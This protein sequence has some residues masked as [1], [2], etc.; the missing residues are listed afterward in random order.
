MERK[1]LIQKSST[2]VVAHGVIAL[3]GLGLAGY[4]GY[5]ITVSQEWYTYTILIIA[6]L[7]GILYSIAFLR[8]ILKPKILAEYDENNLY[9]IKRN[10]KDVAL[11]W[12]Q[13]SCVENSDNT[14]WYQQY[15][16]SGSLVLKDEE[17]NKYAIG[18]V[19]DPKTCLQQ[20]ASM[21][22]DFVQQKKLAEESAQKKEESAN[23][24]TPSSPSEEPG[25]KPE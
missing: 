12:E 6:C 15:F 9:I 3:F 19:E 1:P 22:E 7:L 2:V 14:S 13:L 4:F 20:I 18:P 16:Q 17:A 11:A 5:E 10:G 8:E 24:I 21:K 23:D 25:S